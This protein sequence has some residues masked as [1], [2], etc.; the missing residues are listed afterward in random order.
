MPKGLFIILDHFPKTVHMKED[1]L[2]LQPVPK[3]PSAPIV[4]ENIWN[5]DSIFDGS[6]N[7]PNLKQDTTK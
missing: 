1:V 6:K 7:D 3:V 2:Y 4:H 5:P